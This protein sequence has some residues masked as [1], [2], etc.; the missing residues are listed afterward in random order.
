MAERPRSALQRIASARAVRCLECFK[1]I[2]FRIVKRQDF[3]EACDL[4]HF[5][6]DPFGVTH[7]K[8]SA[9]R[10][11]RLGAPE[12]AIRVLVSV[13]LVLNRFGL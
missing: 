11:D 5:L 7:A 3:V 10:L 6:Y 13:R 1:C 2:G 8:F 9:S 4:N 12:T